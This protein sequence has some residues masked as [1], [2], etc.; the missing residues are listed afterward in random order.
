MNK[1]KYLLD[2][3]LLEKYLG[4]SMGQIFLTTVGEFIKEETN[5]LNVNIEFAP[6]PGHGVPSGFL[7]YDG[8]QSPEPVKDFPV[9]ILRAAYNRSKKMQE[10]VETS[11]YRLMPAYGEYKC[12]CY[13][14][15]EKEYILYV[16]S[17]MSKSNIPDP[18]I[19]FKHWGDVEMWFKAEAKTED[20]K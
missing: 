19:Y 3:D 18:R 13:A 1:K 15:K 12:C 5:K 6:P 7:G 17:G 4:H 20:T 2:Q 8:Y 9:S 16:K 11:G 10:G 14:F